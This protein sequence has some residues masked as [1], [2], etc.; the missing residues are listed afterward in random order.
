[1]TKILYGKSV[2][3]E[4]KKK[5]LEEKDSLSLRGIL[6]Q[7][8]IVRVGNKKDDIA[9][10]TRIE[11]NCLELG[12][13]LKKVQVDNNITTVN[14]VSLLNEINNDDQTH[15]ILIF[16][17]LPEAIDLNLIR[18]SINPNKDIDSMT[19][20]NSE[21]VFSGNNTALEPCT[22][23]AV[24]EILKF[25]GYEMAGSK[26]GIINRSL[27]LGKPLA[28]MLLQNQATVSIGH[29][30][31]KNLTEFTNSNDIVVTGIGKAKFFNQDYF[32][33]SSTIIDVGI[34]FDEQGL[35]G[36]V[37]YASVL[38]KIKAITPVPGG[39]GAVTSMMLFMNLLKAIKLQFN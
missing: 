5:F 30:K 17:P 33:E 20:V 29:S 31:T 16:R 6:P 21:K 38:E 22:P 23:L 18:A 11:K 12:V 2:A 13:N 24:I 4:L 3:E 1:M 26:V 27:V 15:G 7:I 34:N 35:C 8:C 25:Y 28:M 37:D 10:E 14:L 19:I 36:D 32:N 9:Y 39:V